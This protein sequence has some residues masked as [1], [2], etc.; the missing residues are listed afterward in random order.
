MK[1]REKSTRKEISLSSTKV[2][3]SFSASSLPTSSLHTSRHTHSLSLP[4]MPSHSPL[5]YSTSICCHN[6]FFRSSVDLTHT[7]RHTNTHSQSSMFLPLW[8]ICAQIC[9][10]CFC[11]HHHHRHYCWCL[12]LLNFSIQLFLIYFPL[13]YT[14]ILATNKQQ[15][16]KVFWN[17]NFKVLLRFCQCYFIFLHC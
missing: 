5:S 4:F 17:S 13:L 10:C 8:N 16:K 11:Y 1:E 9:R 14:A 7:H 3:S 12:L 6:S 2:A 15:A